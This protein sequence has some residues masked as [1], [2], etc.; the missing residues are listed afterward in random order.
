MIMK[1]S[2]KDFISGRAMDFV[3]YKSENI[4]IHH[5][6]PQSYCEKNN[7]DKRKWN[8]IINK[9]PLSYKTNRK[10]GGNA[11]SKYL[12]SLQLNVTQTELENYLQSHW[13]KPENL[14]ADDFE[15]F[16]AN[17]AGCLL[18]AVEEVTEKKILGRDS[19]EVKKFFGSSI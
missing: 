19:V 3:S 9:T 13:I 2:A 12:K 18:D 8:S 10:I 7:L 14:F 4:D 5:I 6:F 1:N 11:P 17:R 16:I 15:N